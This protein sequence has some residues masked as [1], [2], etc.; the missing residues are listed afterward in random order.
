MDREEPSRKKVV[1]VVDK[2]VRHCVL[3]DPTA[4]KYKIPPQM[5]TRDGLEEKLSVSPGKPDTREPELREF[6]GRGFMVGQEGWRRKPQRSLQHSDSM[7][8]KQ[9]LETG[10]CTPP[11]REQIPHTKTMSPSPKELLMTA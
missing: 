4:L 2:V 9:R 11:P 1:S 8:P 5:L 7:E 3:L 6:P 10:T